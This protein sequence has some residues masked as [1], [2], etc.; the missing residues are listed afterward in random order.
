MN[1]F[2]D[3]MNSFLGL[4]M[5]NAY[6]TADDEDYIC[7]ENKADRSY[8]WSDLSTFIA[9]MF[10]IL[11]VFIVLGTVTEILGILFS[12]YDEDKRPKTQSF[13]MKLILSFS[14]YSNFNAIMSTK[15]GGK[16]TLTCLNGIR[17]ISMM[18]V[19]LGHDFSFMPENANL[20][21]AYGLY[22]FYRGKLGLSFEAI[23]NALPSVD[24]FFLMR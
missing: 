11:G 1:L 14:L 16:D 13:G 15:T 7:L 12:F 21:N 20:R 2:R 24:S 9:V 10:S 18:W 8:Q 19:V 23:M 22:V 6:L 3:N 17:F 4:E 5:F